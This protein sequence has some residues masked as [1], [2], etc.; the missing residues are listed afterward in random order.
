MHNQI[1]IHLEM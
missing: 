1:M